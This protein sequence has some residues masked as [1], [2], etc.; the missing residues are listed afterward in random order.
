MADSDKRP[1]GI[2]GDISDQLAGIFR[3][4]LPGVLVVGTARLAY[5]DLIA[6]P[7]LDSWQN[8]LV[9]AVIT[10]VLGN[11]WF[12]LNRYGLHQ[13]VDYVLYLFKSNGPARTGP[14]LGFAYLD[15]LGKY[16]RKSLH[17]PETSRRAADHIRFRASTVLLA[18]TLGELLGLAI[19]LP[20]LVIAKHPAASTWTLESTPLAYPMGPYGAPTFL[21]VA[22]D[23]TNHPWALTDDAHSFRIFTR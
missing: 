6:I 13:V 22:F 4:M 8:V 14:I 23:A 18:L 16:T 19:P 9:L 3:H 17:T 20:E 15:D 1:I 11:T 12:A 10:T 7:K 2:L 5:P 21:R